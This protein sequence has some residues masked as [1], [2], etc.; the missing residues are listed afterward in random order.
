ML[1][2]VSITSVSFSSLCFCI[3]ANKVRK[4]IR[5]L[6]VDVDSLFGFH[7]FYSPEQENVAEG[8]GPCLGLHTFWEHD[9]TSSAYRIN[10]TYI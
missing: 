1:C 2:H 4:L 6:T 10:E 9:D 8:N 7:F 3:R 5:L